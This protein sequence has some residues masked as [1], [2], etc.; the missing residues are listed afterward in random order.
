M[1]DGW[2]L[3]GKRTSTEMTMRHIVQPPWWRIGLEL[4]NPLAWLLGGPTWAEPYL[5]LR[6][7][8]DE[9]GRAHAR[10]TGS[11]PGGWPQ[12]HSWEIPDGPI[13]R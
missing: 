10:T 4:I 3:D 8:V 1:N 2:D 9:D 6:V 7:W 12:H 11:V 13:G 5:T